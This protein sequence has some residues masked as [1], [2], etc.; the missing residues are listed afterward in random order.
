MCLLRDGGLTVDTH[1]LLSEKIKGSKRERTSFDSEIMC[2][3][4]RQVE[5]D[6]PV[7]LRKGKDLLNG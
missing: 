3:V 4:F 6:G 1:I 5:F 7:G 2:S